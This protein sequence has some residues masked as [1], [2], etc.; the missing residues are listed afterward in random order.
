MLLLTLLV[1]TQYVLPTTCEEE[2]QLQGR[3]FLTDKLC[4]LGL[5]NCSP[6]ND[7]GYDHQAPAHDA[8]HVPQPVYVH[9]HYHH[10]EP[11]YQDDP[12]TSSSSEHASSS[13]NFQ[14]SGYPGSLD[15]PYEAFSPGN[16]D[17]TYQ[18]SFSENIRPGRGAGQCYCVTQSQCPPGRVVGYTTKDYS[19]LINPRNKGIH[20]GIAAAETD[21]QE[22]SEDILDSLLKTDVFGRARSLTSMIEA[23]TRRRRSAEGSSSHEPAN[24]H[25]NLNSQFDPNIDLAHQIAESLTDKRSI[26]DNGSFGPAGY[27]PPSCGGPAS[28][29]VCCSVNDGVQHG[30]V[31]QQ[32]AGLG[33]DV[34]R[35]TRQGN[36][37]AATPGQCGRRNAHGVTGRINNPAQAYNEGDT[38]FGEY[39]WQVALLK[40]EEYDNVYVCGGSLIDSS[41]ILTAAHCIKQLQPAQIRARLGEW[42][43]NN[44]S[45]FF[46]NIEY[47]VISATIHPEYYSNNL[48]NDLAV[49]KIAG[50]VDYASNPHI[51]PVCIPHAH[52][53]FAGQ[54]C[55]VTGWG[56]DAF[57]RGGAYQQVLKEVEVPVLLDFDCERKLKRTRLGLDFVLHPSFICAGGEEGKDSCKG[58]GG[59]PLVC[60]TGGSWQ[61]A[62]IVSWGVGCGEKDIPGVYVKVSQFTH[63]IREVVINT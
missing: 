52:Q 42:D 12:Y 46:P 39:P 48:Y 31:V 25:Y 27:R 45:E 53:D 38:E 29:Y 32:D 30:D 37:I 4:S 20:Q 49:L 14:D 9:Q 21:K 24:L 43:V 59:G 60:Q 3:N 47:D 36:D 1:T 50:S 16:E 7:R 19:A 56:K 8:H 41:H 17:N 40:K 34:V 55:Y 28:G 22:N 35:D 15:S 44:D 11:V 61:L 54:R 2:K 57:G 63:W 58:D 33:P 23:I 5:G 18:T 26:A 51:S 6:A 10:S 62:G 13:Y